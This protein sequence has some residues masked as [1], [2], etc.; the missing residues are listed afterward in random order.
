M[1]TPLSL[2]EEMKNE[3]LETFREALGKWNLAT[4]G[5]KFQFGLGGLKN[6]ENKRTRVTFSA[7]AYAKMYLL[8]N[9]FDSE[10]AWHGL[11]N[12]TED[13]FFIYDILIYPQEVTGSTVNTDQTA[14]EMWLFNQ[15][16]NVF[17]HIRM[18]GHSHV[19]FGTTPSSVDT[20][21]QEQII[22]QLGDND[23]Y[24]FMIVNKK[25]SA[26]FRIVDRENNI[27]YDT[28]DVSFCVQGGGV[29][30]EFY[31]EAKEMVKTKSYSYTDTGYAN[32]N[33]RGIGS[34]YPSVGTMS[35]GK[36]NASEKDTGKKP[37][38]QKKSKPKKEYEKRW[39][40]DEMTRYYGDAYEDF[41]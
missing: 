4:D 39:W 13:G 37:E 16:D 6:Y 31:D 33:G 11:V 9:L 18:Q 20:T 24:I 40:E 30:K 7:A 12:R 34:I 29:T 8:V 2:T 19:N 41:D 17:N 32:T 28:D 3:L 23:Y 22:E 27:Q 1:S 10:V 5:L 21:H 35:A 38:K 25:H 14:Y 36:R 15:D 26:Y